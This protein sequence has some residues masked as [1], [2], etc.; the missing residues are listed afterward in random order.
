MKL[1]SATGGLIRRAHGTAIEQG[2]FKALSPC[3]HRCSLPFSWQLLR[4]SQAQEVC[5]Y[6]APREFPLSCA[7]DRKLFAV[8]RRGAVDE[9]GTT[10]FRGQQMP[11]KKIRHT[12]PPVQDFRYEEA[13][14]K[15]NPPAGMAPTYKDGTFVVKL[16]GVDIYDPLTGETE[17]T[18]GS[19][20]AAWFLDTDYDGKTFHICQSFFPGDPDA[21]DKLQRALKAQI[22]P[23]VFE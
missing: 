14:R 10:P 17:H 9:V 21:W 20:V 22:D 6:N 11:K 8:A 5:G 4:D 2:G 23:E 12:S 3:A 18:R 1:G 19:H 15:N 13:K 16:R 7:P